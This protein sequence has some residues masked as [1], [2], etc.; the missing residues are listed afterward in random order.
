[1]NYVFTGIPSISPDNE[2]RKKIEVSKNMSTLAIALWI[3]VGGSVDCS[4]RNDFEVVGRHDQRARLSDFA[5][6][7]IVVL[8]FFGTDCPLARLYGPRVNALA[9][10][11]GSAGVAFLGIDANEGDSIEDLARFAEQNKIGF[12]L[13]KDP[14]GTVAV[15]FGATRQL[16]VFVLDHRRNVKY[17]G[18]VD[19]QYAPGFR[20]SEPTRDDL[21][22]AIEELVSGK[23]EIAVAETEESDWPIEDSPRRSTAVTEAATPSESVGECRPDDDANAFAG[24]GRQPTANFVHSSIDDTS[25][26][27]I[28]PGQSMTALSLALVFTIGCWLIGRHRAKSRTLG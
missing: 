3:C 5:D 1:M 10:Q 15:Q 27:P 6:R 20:R 26:T 24:T 2:L 14:D 18:R 7:D 4:P 23:S 12:P 17:H 13:F 11:Y 8:V 22:E 25:E 28:V 9:D 21:K 16:E 19:D